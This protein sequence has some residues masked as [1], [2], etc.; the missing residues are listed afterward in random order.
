LAA[1]QIN[2]TWGIKVWFPEQIM[3][4]KDGTKI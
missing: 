3:A 4:R 2:T 1:E